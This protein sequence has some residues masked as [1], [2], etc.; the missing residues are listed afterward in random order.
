MIA[1]KLLTQR[2]DGTLGPLFI[3]KKQRISFNV[4]LEAECHPTPGYAVRPGWHCTPNPIAPHLSTNGRVWCR[5]RVQGIQTFTRP[6]CQGGQ[7]LLAR[8]M[9]V[10]NLLKTLENGTND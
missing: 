3:N 5:V 4:W 7:W 6:E 10:L 8:R 1:Y 9:K 2:A